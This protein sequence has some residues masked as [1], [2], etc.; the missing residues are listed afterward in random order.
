M[1]L[2]LALLALLGCLL[3]MLLLPSVGARVRNFG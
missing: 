2:L 1:V 3:L